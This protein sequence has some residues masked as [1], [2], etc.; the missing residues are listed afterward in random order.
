L[1]A[2]GEAL[3]IP[4][5]NVFFKERY[6][7][8]DA[9]LG[10]LFSLESVVAGLVIFLGPALANRWGKVRSVVAGQISSIAFLM[11]LGFVPILPVAALAFLVRAALMFTTRPLYAAFSMEQTPPGE[12]ARVNAVLALAWGLGS[13]IGPGISGLVQARWGFNPLFLATGSL[14]LIAALWMLVYFYNAETIQ[15]RPA[16]VRQ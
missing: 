3:L 11:V 8:P 13:A 15:R 7:L 10:G 6:A 9:W 4:Y 5:L 12:R 1:V 14:Y 2:L 16:A